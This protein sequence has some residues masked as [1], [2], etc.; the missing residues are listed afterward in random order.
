MKT[1]DDFFVI[2]GFYFTNLFLGQLQR[3]YIEVRFV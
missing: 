3:L 1:A 2:S